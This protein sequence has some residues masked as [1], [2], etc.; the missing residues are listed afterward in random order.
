MR[1]LRNLNER[2]IGAL[3]GRSYDSI[4]NAP[5][6][7]R[8]RPWVWKPEGGESFEEVRARVA[9]VL[10]RLAEAHRERDVVVVSRGGV[11][12]ALWAHVSGEWGGHACDPQL[13]DCH[14]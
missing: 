14:D 10:D 11:M 3:H 6:Y 13:R 8:A 5:G 9:P 4:V 7:D 2:D 12:M 1:S